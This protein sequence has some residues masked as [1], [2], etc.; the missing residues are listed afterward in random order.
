ML[1]VNSFEGK[2]EFRLMRICH[3]LG[4]RLEPVPAVLDL[5]CESGEDEMG[6]RL[7]GSLELFVL[8]PPVQVGQLGSVHNALGSGDWLWGET[9]G[10]GEERGEPSLEI[11]ITV[12][13]R[14]KRPD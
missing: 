3:L 14:M 13:A 10:M 2:V 11:V 6:L 4:K 9:R 1:A 7:L 8:C 12:E 5:R